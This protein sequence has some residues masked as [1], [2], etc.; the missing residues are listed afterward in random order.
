MAWVLKACSNEG[1]I[2]QLQD[3]SIIKSE[4]VAEVM[5]QT[6]R[7][8]YC[9]SK[10]P[11]IDEPEPIGCNTK[12]SSPHIHAYAL[13]NLSNIIKEDS[14]ILDIGSGSGYLAACFARLIEAKAKLKGVK[15]SG[16]V[17]SIEHQPKM[18]DFAIKNLNS[19]DPNL[20]GEDKVRIVQGDG[21]KGYTQYAPYDVIHVGA[22]VQ[23]V[24]ND[25]LLQLNLG[26]RMVVPIGEKG[27]DKQMIQYDRI[28]NYEIVK[29]MLSSVLYVPLE[30]L[31]ES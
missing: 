13:E 9:P 8:Y 31:K 14:R 22:A 3:L 23:D 6:D 30:D 24:P 5:K 29:T 26:G 7:K 1:L 28:S 4:I 12:I 16:K 19:D 17:I 21:R 2:Q 20:I 25:L 15:N 27:E 11:F 18:A 10:H